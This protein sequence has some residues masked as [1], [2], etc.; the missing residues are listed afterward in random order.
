MNKC[1]LVNKL[2]VTQLIIKSQKG[3]QLNEREVYSINSNEVQGLL[4]FDVVNKGASFELVY[5][6]SGFITFREFLQTPLNRASFAGILSNILE[7]LNLMQGAYINQYYLLMDFDRVMVNPATQRIYFIYVPIQGFENNVS[8]RDFL[9]DIIQYSTFAPGED[10]SYV[11]R[12]IEILNRGINYSVFE[13]EEYI[14]KLSG[15]KTADASVYR[16]C[17]QC[18]I[19]VKKGT[20]YCPECGAKV[21]GVNGKSGRYDPLER[22]DTEDSTMMNRDL[23]EQ[24]AERSK[25]DRGRMIG[26]TTVLGDTF[27]ETVMSD[28]NEPDKPN[29]PYLIREKNREK[30]P[31]D[32]PSF[33]I[34]KERKYSDYFVSDNNAVSRSHAD[35]ITREKR[36]YII[37]R[38]STNRTY[39]DGRAIPAEREI[40][41]FPNTRIRLAN[42]NF[43]FCFDS[44]L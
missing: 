15:I 8:I 29:Y 26:G 2:G 9:L 38:N 12:Y 39:I 41:I 34:G 28:P 13:L 30:I 6:I 19:N 10:N 42:E 36:Y 1:K 3:Q 20:N 14:K 21:S 31:I 25:E 35:I 11:T 27:G 18:H 23:N 7:N 4:H 32:K 5:N 44:Q 43:I 16:E 37:D 40:E 22:K 24:V 33:R 17:P